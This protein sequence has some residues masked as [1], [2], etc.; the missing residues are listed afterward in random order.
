MKERNETPRAAVGD[1]V[2]RVRPL[3]AR[4]ADRCA[5]ELVGVRYVN[6]AGGWVLR[7][8]LDRPGGVTV[9]ECAA[10]SRRLSVLLDVEDS[11]PHAYTL[12]V[13]SPGVERELCG[14][15]EYRRYVGRRVR[16]ETRGSVRGRKLIRGVLDG[17]EGEVLRIREESGDALEVPLE[18]V[19]RA[20]LEMDL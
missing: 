13:T 20:R 2:A 5:C 15:E 8:I 19:A 1:V 12:E 3:A 17:L 9:E 11:I 7:V 10:V 6:E 14:A 18:R 4:V 16:I